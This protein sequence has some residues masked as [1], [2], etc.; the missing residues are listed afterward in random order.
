M[1]AAAGL[2]VAAG[3]TGA[4]LLGYG[5]YLL[6]TDT[7]AG[8]PLR[9]AWWLAGALVLHDGVLAPLVFCLGLL[10]GAG[11][12]RGVVRAGLVTAG[13]LTLVAGPVL[14][15]PG[16]PANASVLPL[17]YPRNL[18]LLLAAVACATLVGVWWRRRGR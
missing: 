8:T 6:W 13:C 4:A 17:D 5:A 2:R 9:V 12:A 7:R 16:R 14:L 10:L 11:R 18:A 3:A 15:R 1:R